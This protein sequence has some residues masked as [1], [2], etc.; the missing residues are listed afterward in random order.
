MPDP[1]SLATDLSKPGAGWTN[2]GPVIKVAKFNKFVFQGQLI[3][4]PGDGT[5]FE[6]CPH[7]G[8]QGKRGKYY[9]QGTHDHAKWMEEV[10]ARASGADKKPHAPARSPDPRRQKKSRWANL[11]NGTGN[12]VD[13]KN[14]P[15]KN[16]SKP[17]VSRLALKENLSTCLVTDLGASH[18]EANNFAENFIKASL[19]GMD[20]LED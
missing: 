17:S 19:M 7:H 3:A 20:L 5:V 4:H 12:D 8:R 9:K 11:Q 13:K 10:K 15:L 14:D 1:V 2:D 16:S 18:E 6:W